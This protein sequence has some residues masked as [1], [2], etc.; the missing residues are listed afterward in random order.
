MQSTIVREWIIFSQGGNH[1]VGIL[2]AAN[3]L[4]DLGADRSAAYVDELTSPLLSP[5]RSLKK[6]NTFLKIVFFSFAF[7]YVPL[8]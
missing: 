4:W 5:K 1:Q 8:I 3:K 6:C 2:S 7:F